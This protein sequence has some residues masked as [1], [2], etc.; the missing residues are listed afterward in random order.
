V[1]AEISRA[2]ALDR[3]QNFQMLPCDPVAAIFDELL[4]RS[5]DNIG[6]LDWRPLHHVLGGVSGLV[7]FFEIFNESSGLTAALKC[8]FDT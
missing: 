8:R 1:I 2:A 7:V 5:A 3:S 4:S 6:H